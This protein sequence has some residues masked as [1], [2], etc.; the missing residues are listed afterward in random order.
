MSACCNMLLQGRH[1]FRRCINFISS[2]NLLIKRESNIYWNTNIS[3]CDL[4][5]LLTRQVISTVVVAVS[6]GTFLPQ[7]PGLRAV[8][9]P[10]C[11]GEPQQEQQRRQQDEAHAGP[12]HPQAAVGLRRHLGF[13]RWCR[14]STR[15]CARLSRG[16]SRCQKEHC[17]VMGDIV[18]SQ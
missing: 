6:S 10:V 17:D 9:M 2:C 4:I 11:G 18:T 5:C 13:R 7:P 14:M 1:M 3:E 15:R 16:V 12:E 8:V